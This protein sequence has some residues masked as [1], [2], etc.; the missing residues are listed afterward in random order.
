MTSGA[1]LFSDK[2]Q[3]SAYAQYRPSYPDDVFSAVYEY[4]GPPHTDVALDVATGALT[5]R[6]IALRTSAMVTVVSVLAYG[7]QHPGSSILN[8]LVANQ[9]PHAVHSR[10]R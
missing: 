4:A 5:L 7:P 9:A 2:D 1:E 8:Q 3:A 10:L 6:C